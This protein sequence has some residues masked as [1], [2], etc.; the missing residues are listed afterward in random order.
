MLE[1]VKI[2]TSRRAYEFRPD[3]LRLST[4]SLQPIQQQIQQLFN[5]QSSSIG[6]PI[7][8]FGDVPMTYPPGVAFN[9]GVWFHEGNQIVP[10]RFIHF[11]QNRIVIDVAGT[12][13]VIDAIAERLFHFLS[14]LHAVD[15]TPVIGEPEQV[16]NYSEITAK[17]PVALDTIFTRSLRRLFS[18]MAN[19]SHSKNTILMPTLAL[20]AVPGNQVLPGAPGANDTR[21]F[22]LAIRSG[23]RPEDNIYFSGAPLDSDTHLA[24]IQELASIIAP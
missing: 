7:P 24:Y 15:G 11:E 4:L 19:A 23:T 20:Q 12:T 8:T 13:S 2:L 3:D 1:Q 6:S 17:F 10:I 18:K 22:T 9:L 16:L 5:F 14:E 21:A